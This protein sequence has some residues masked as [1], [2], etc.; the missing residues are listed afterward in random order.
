MAG[1][2]VAESSG[3]NNNWV[4]SRQRAEAVRAE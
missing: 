3:N 1:V 2:V 4:H